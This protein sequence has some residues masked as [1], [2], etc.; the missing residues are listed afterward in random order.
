MKKIF[1]FC[2]LTLFTSS[3]YAS[4]SC[5]GT[6]RGTTVHPTNGTIYVESIGADI[7]WPIICSLVSDYGGVSPETCKS[8]H[9]TLLTAQTTGKKVRFWF[10]DDGDCT[11]HRAWGQLTGWYFG[12]MLVD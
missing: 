7:R 2:L 8:I 5:A 11:T 12:P 4:Y 10:N 6:V 3:V 1:L 9:A